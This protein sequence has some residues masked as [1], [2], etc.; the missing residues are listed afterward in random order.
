MKTD[1]KLDRFLAFRRHKDSPPHA[2]EMVRDIKTLLEK[3][4]EYANM[5][6]QTGALPPL[7]DL[8]KRTEAVAQLPE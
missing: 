1:L 3:S 8:L 2:E 5:T 4:I 6:G 7:Q